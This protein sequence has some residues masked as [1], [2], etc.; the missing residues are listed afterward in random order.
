MFLIILA[1]IIGA[2]VGFN[3]FV[4]ALLVL[5]IIVCIVQVSDV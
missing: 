2:L 5:G 4:L 3:V 1:L